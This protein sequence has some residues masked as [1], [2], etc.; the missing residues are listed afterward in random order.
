ME[1]AFGEAPETSVQNV[2]IKTMQLCKAL[3]T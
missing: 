3:G 1:N 2:I